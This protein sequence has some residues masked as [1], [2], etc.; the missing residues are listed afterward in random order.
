L[1]HAISNTAPVIDFLFGTSCVASQEWNPIL[2]ARY[3]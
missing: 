2:G 3:K 1:A